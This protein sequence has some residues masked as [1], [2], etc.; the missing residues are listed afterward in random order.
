MKS[1]K[2][3][4]L[5]L[6]FSSLQVLGQITTETFISSAEYTVEDAMIASG[7]LSNINF[8]SDPSMNLYSD[9]SS[10][11]ILQRSA[12]RYDLSGIPANA[13]IVSASLTIYPQSVNPSVNFSYSIERAQNS[14]ASESITWNS[15]PNTY[16]NDQIVFPYPSSINNSV[17]N[18]DVKDHIQKMVSY[19]NSNNGWIL[20]LLNESN[21]NSSHG[22][23]FH[24]SE[25]SIS[26]KHPSLEVSYVLPIEITPS[27][28]HCT[29]SSSN[30]SAVIS[31][32]SGSN[33]YSFYSVHRIDRDPNQIAVENPVLIVSS[34]SVNSNS[35]SLNNLLPGIYEVLIKDS[36]HDGSNTDYNKTYFE[37]Y[38]Y[39]L[40]GKEGEETTC[41]LA[42]NNKG[43]RSVEVL[44]NISNQSAN[45]DWG[46]ENQFA[47]N[48]LGISFT[49]T[50]TIGSSNVNSFE[51]ESLMNFNIQFDGSLAFVKANLH[52]Y[53]W[54]DY[55]QTNTSSNAAYYTA[56]TEPWNERVVTWNTKPSTDPSNSVYSIKTAVNNGSTAE[57]KD[58]I[59]MLPLVNYWKTNPNYGFEM[60]VENY[61]QAS[62]STR[63]HKKLLGNDNGFFEISFNVESPISPEYNESTELGS[64]TVN[65]PSGSL[66]F[67]YLISYD[68]IPQL[69]EIWAGVKD[70]IPMDSITFFSGKENSS[71]Y[72]FTGLKNGSYHVAVFDNSGVKIFDGNT[73]LRPQFNFFQ[74]VNLAVS[75]LGLV[76]QSS[77]SSDAKGTLVASLKKGEDGGVEFKVVQMNAGIIGFN[78]I[79]DGQVSTGSDL[80]F[81]IEIDGS[82]NSD[83]FLNGAIVSGFSVDN[84]DFIRLEKNNSKFQLY[85]NDVLLFTQNGTQPATN[86][87]KVDFILKE[88]VDPNADRI[89][90][91]FFSYKD[92]F[93]QTLQV[94]NKSG[95]RYC[96]D[97][98]D[99]IRVN[100]P[101]SNLGLNLM[102]HVTN[103]FTGSLTTLSGQ[104]FVD[105]SLPVGTYSIT[106][107]LDDPVNLVSYP[108]GTQIVE[109]GYHILWD[110]QSSVNHTV[111]ATNALV[112]S[113]I[114][115]YGESSS[116]NILN[117]GNNAEFVKFKIGLFHLPVVF[118]NVPLTI[119][120]R[121]GIVSLI[122]DNTGLVY[123]QVEKIDMGWNNIINEYCKISVL[124]P[125]SGQLTQ[126]YFG[127]TMPNNVFKFTSTP[128]SA[129]SFTMEV[130]ENNISRSF[131]TYSGLAQSPILRVKGQTWPGAKIFDTYVSYCYQIPDQYVQLKRKLEGGYYKVQP[132]NIL[133]VEYFEEYND[134]DQILSFKIKNG[135]G[136]IVVDDNSLSLTSIYGDNRFD[137]DVANLIPNEFYILEISNEKNETFY[138]RFK[139]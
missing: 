44:N 3:V 42:N 32:S 34:S 73:D 88:K 46:S 126:V 69:A 104:Q 72:T 97:I 29:A 37:T 17:H 33:A 130:T 83:V 138:L 128:L 87:Y 112:S 56:V 62:Y 53:G 99:V 111:T 95:T 122:D 8:G 114:L 132:D 103:I 4:Y 13:T 84:S 6:S 89:M 49:G 108:G 50:N 7:G 16:S 12:I 105:I 125:N 65:A 76:E 10:G 55:Y 1:L 116:V 9:I 129:N 60:A 85:K 93:H 23:S 36:L 40:V 75:G 110:L 66:P 137:F 41:I 58:T 52:L 133:K 81:G 80:V 70:S 131:Q 45:Y 24:T 91:E 26:S 64:I 77:E 98:T 47:G 106:F 82:G 86:D 68:S 121:E 22:V 123:A 90:L 113:P 38:K 15:Q 35:F 51:N 59:D 117:T 21:Y 20:K 54:T 31:Y 30:G 124:D 25:S 63:D 43:V 18:I 96:G 109:V 134:Q 94:M 115:N 11:P 120:S 136:E 27:V 107:F 139:K 71:S 135:K 78:N 2:L 48:K 100:N 118:P 119:P 28:T 19:P 101:Y 67:T 57:R 127:A 79:E 74:K 39:F 61:N 102:V 5:V 92:F 14:W